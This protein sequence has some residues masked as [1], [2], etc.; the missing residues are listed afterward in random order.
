MKAN[1]GWLAACA[2]ASALGC[3][4]PPAAVDPT[5]GYLDDPAFARAELTASLVNP[6]NGYSR[7]RLAHYATGDAAGG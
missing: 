4:P 1:V 7:L 3:Q 2:M 6:E 5:T